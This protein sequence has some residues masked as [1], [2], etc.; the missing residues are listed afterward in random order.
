MNKN[1][2]YKNTYKIAKAIFWLCVTGCMAMATIQENPC[3]EITD[4]TCYTMG[5]LIYLGPNIPCY[6]APCVRESH[7]INFTV[8]GKI[9]Y[10]LLRRE[11]YEPPTGRTNCLSRVLEHWGTKTVVKRSCDSAA[12]CY[13]SSTTD[14]FVSVTCEDDRLDSNSP[15]C[16][17]Q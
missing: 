10:Q 14:E 6:G 9:C 1:T 2:Q 11:G 12:G 13:V 7:Y 3:Y 4:K 8:T 5:Q 17:P 15:E 16:Q